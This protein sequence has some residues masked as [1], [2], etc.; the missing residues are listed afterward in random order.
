[1]EEHSPLDI[2]H[3]VDGE[4]ITAGPDTRLRDVLALLAEHRIG[5]VL[6]VESDR[7]VGIFTERDLVRSLSTATGDLLDEPIES[8]MTPDPVTVDVRDRFHDVYMKM[9]SLHVRHLP[10]VD[11][12]DLVGIVSMRDLMH[13]YQNTLIS[14]Y[15]ETRY[16]LR[17]VESLFG[18]EE[19]DR[20]QRL[21]DEL[22]KYK[23]LSMTDE[24]T[25][26]YNKRYFANRLSEEVAR[27]RRHGS[28]LALILADVD[29]FKA[30]NDEHGHDIG[31]A[32]LRE[33]G[34]ILK[35][36]VEHEG[37]VSRL[38]KSDII[39]R[40]G[41][42]EFVVILPETPLDGA[43][44]TGDK[45]RRAVADNLF[46]EGVRVTLSLG[47]AA[48]GDATE[49]SS[50]LIKQADIALYQAKTNGRNRVEAS[51]PDS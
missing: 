6:I 38:R 49:S 51:R 11:G 46:P 44:V 28:P 12:C 5:A 43:M 17:E 40:Y 9:K 2:R 37:V 36:G 16:R 15:E 19:D 24:L 41:G 39:A 23:R 42:E 4:P 21:A 29:Q 35:K 1:M 3:Y 14:Q 10:I 26:L 30:V 25:G 27:S 31:D 33:I 8:L 20:V 22:A 45:L 7:L 32:V 34:R 50:R 48:M 18:L 13:T 47:V